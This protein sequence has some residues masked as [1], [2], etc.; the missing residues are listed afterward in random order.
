[1]FVMQPCRAASDVTSV[2]AP[3][4]DKLDAP[5]PLPC[6]EAFLPGRVTFANGNSAARIYRQASHAI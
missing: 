1:M 3:Q 4:A 5:R 6:N 2:I